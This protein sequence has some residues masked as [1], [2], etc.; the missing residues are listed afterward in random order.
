MTATAIEPLI[1]VINAGSSSIKFSFYEGERRLLTGQVDGLGAHPSASATGPDGEAIA[2]PDLGGKPPTAPSE[3]LPT[4]IP[5]ARERLGT[6]RLAALG[7]RVVHG[8]LRHSRPAR[9]TPELLAE[10]EALVPLAPLHEPHNLA[11]IKMAMT[12]NPDLPQVACLYVAG[13]SD[14]RSLGPSGRPLRAKDIGDGDPVRRAAPRPKRRSRGVSQSP[15]GACIQARS[16]VVQ[17][18]GT[19][20]DGEAGEAPMSSYEIVGI[21]VAARTLVAIGERVTLT[22][23]YDNT[24]ASRSS[25]IHL[26]PQS[27][28]GSGRAG[29]DRDLFCRPG[30]RT[31][32]RGDRGDGGQPQGGAPFRRGHPAAPQDRSGRCGDAA[33]VR[34]AHGF[35]A[36]AAAAARAVWVSRTDPRGSSPEQSGGGCQKPAARGHRHP[37]DAGGADPRPRASS[38]RS[39]TIRR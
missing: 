33:R 4:I 7:H 6:R 28:A 23:A 39:R 35:C 13:G 32:R 3:V 34:P 9:V 38:G 25:L 18:R 14:E 17:G 30:L 36:V 21:D 16:T 27:A 29:S 15:Q 5:W 24:P 26:G 8:G 12:L 37:A 11:P 31:G 22:A 1:G 19:G 10:L 2:P 20:A